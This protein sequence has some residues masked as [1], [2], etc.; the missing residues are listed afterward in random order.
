MTALKLGGFVC[1]ICLRADRGLAAA[2]ARHEDVAADA[3]PDDDL[4]G[5]G[6]VKDVAVGRAR[7][8]GGR[9]RARRQWRS[10]QGRGG[11]GQ[12]AS[13]QAW[14][15]ASFLSEALGRRSGVTYDRED[16]GPREGG[17]VRG[18]D[19]GAVSA[20]RWSAD[21][22]AQP[23]EGKA[24]DMDGSGPGNVR[25]TAPTRR[26][27]RRSAGGRAWRV[28]RR[29]GRCDTASGS[30]VWFS[31]APPLIQRQISASSRAVRW[32]EVVPIERA[33]TSC[34]PFYHRSHDNYKA[35]FNSCL[36]TALD[37]MG[38]FC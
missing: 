23:N 12:R 4:R 6:R 33:W 3:D 19:G 27:R 28:R 17:V 5:A 32:H 22:V 21:A 9:L 37:R 7:R 26:R 14:H 2:G 30:S 36:A 13:F 31:A 18:T 34:A 38:V 16:G 15:R 11:Q 29:C 24:G 35:F 20:Q 10:D 8:D 25:R 1:S